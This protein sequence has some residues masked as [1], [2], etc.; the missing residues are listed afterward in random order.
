MA[1]LRILCCRV[2]EIQTMNTPEASRSPLPG[3]SILNRHAALTKANRAEQG[4]V[5]NACARCGA[6]AY[7]SLMARDETGV[8]RPSGQYQCVQ[9][10][11]VFS[12]IE[13]WRGRAPVTRSA[14]DEDLRPCH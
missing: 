6:T 9:C 1:V 4:R 3:S 11:T 8:M 7:K 14:P 12:Q 10:R 13:Q 5:Q 2:P